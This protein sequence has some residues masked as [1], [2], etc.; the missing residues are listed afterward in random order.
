MACERAKCSSVLLHAEQRHDRSA[1]YRTEQ[2]PESAIDGAE[3]K[4]PRPE[5]DGSP[6]GLASAA[7]DGRYFFLSAG[8]LASGFFES[9]GSGL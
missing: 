6:A 4:M 8:F 2:L 9:L 5:N 7:G 3:T 1:R